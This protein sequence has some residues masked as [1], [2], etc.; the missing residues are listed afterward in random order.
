MTALSDLFWLSHSLAL[1]ARSVTGPLETNVFPSAW[2]KAMI[3]TLYKGGDVNLPKNYRGI[4]LLSVIGKLFTYILNARLVKWAE[5]E[6]VYY[7]EQAGFRKGYSTTDQIFNLSIMVNKYLSKKKGRMYVAFIDFS[8]AFDSVPHLFLITQLLRRGVHG[9]ILCVIKSMYNNLKACVKTNSG[10]TNWFNCTIGTRQGCMLSPF[11]FAMYLNEFIDSLRNNICRGIQVNDY[12]TF[13]EHY[14][15]NIL[16]YADDIALCADNVNDLQILLCTLE[17]YCENWKMNVNMKKSK[18]IV[19]RNGGPLRSNEKWY[20]KKQAMETTSHYKYLGVMFSSKLTWN[21][22]QDE[23]TKQSCRSLINIRK[24]YN[25]C[26]TLPPSMLFKLFDKLIVPILCYGSEVWGYEKSEKIEMVHTK[27]CK[28]VLGV[29]YRTSNTAVLSE[30]GRYPIYIIY[31]VRCIKYW[32]QVTQKEDNRLVKRSLDMSTSLDMMGRIT[33]STHVRNLLC[34]YGFFD[35]WLFGVS[36]VKLFLNVFRQRVKDCYIQEWQQN[37]NFNKK[38]SILKSIKLEYELAQYMSVLREK[39]YISAMAK[40]RCSD[41]TLSIERGRY[42][43][44]A[45]DERI[46]K[47]CSENHN[48][49]VIENEYHFLIQC[50]AYNEYREQYLSQYLLKLTDVNSDIV[51][52]LLGSKNETLISALGVYIHKAFNLRKVRKLIM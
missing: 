35:A 39:K 41:H 33:W 12:V 46:C 48:E 6:N 19:I 9:R 20:F 15:V 49:N 1:F 44:K 45:K 10:F 50:P 16:L 36:N 34:K 29:S 31:F 7:E 26:G 8:C 24:L 30:C 18:I 13:R 14:D 40:I 38:L 25:E 28:W 43:N 51:H 27:F 11:I 23:L 21:L 22:A 37:L 47:Y 42:T 3:C 32:L 17:K 4:S 5:D 52:V 2:G